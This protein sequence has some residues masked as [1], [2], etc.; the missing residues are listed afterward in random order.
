VALAVGELGIDSATDRHTRP[1]KETT[2][3]KHVRCVKRMF[4]EAEDV[5]DIPNPFTKLRGTAAKPVKRWETITPADLKLILD[6]CPQDGWRALFALC[7]YTGMRRGEALALRWRDVHL[8]T[9]RI[10]VNADITHETTKKRVRVCPIE[11]ELLPTG[12]AALLTGYLNAAPE[13]GSEFVCAGVLPAS[14]GLGAIDRQA[15]EII[16]KAGVKPYAKPFHTLRKNWMTTAA[17]K[18]PLH[19]LEEWCGNDREVAKAFYL[20]VDDSYY[21]APP[22]TPEGA[23]EAAVVK[24]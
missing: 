6:A 17:G 1:P 14:G 19:V 13:G 9:N 15:V 3:C 10:T 16:R 4:R 5:Y 12:L 8:D 2:V 7:R 22:A 18:Y 23:G 11:P 24:R 20:A 21:R